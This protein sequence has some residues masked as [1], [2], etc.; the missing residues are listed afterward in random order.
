MKS[1]IQIQIHQNEK[2]DSDPDPSK[3]KV[4][5]RSGSIKMKSRIQ[6]RIHQNEKLDSDPDPSKWKVGLRS[7][8]IKMKS[9]IQIRIHVKCLNPLAWLL[10]NSLYSSF[11]FLVCIKKAL[12]A[13]TNTS[14]LKCK[15]LIVHLIW[16]II[17]FVRTFWNSIILYWT[18]FRIYNI[19]TYLPLGGGA[20]SSSVLFQVHKC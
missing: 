20:E 4:G 10:T 8:S 14:K 13:V 3:G 18:S 6:I 1:W 11:T 12:R 16:A 9:R 17:S 2:S 19:Y 15:P 5:F 7:G